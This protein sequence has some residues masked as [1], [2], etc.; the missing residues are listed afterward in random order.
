MHGKWLQA[1]KNLESP[2]EFL[3]FLVYPLNFQRVY[4]YFINM[5]SSVL[6][7]NED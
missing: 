2:E 5:Q 1:I 3:L 7:E 6:L 4:D